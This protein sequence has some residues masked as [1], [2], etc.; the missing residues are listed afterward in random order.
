MLENELVGV[1]RA[2]REAESVAARV[3][4]LEKELQRTERE[5]TE[6]RIGDGPRIRRLR[7]VFALTLGALAA[8]L[9]LLFWVNDANVQR[10]RAALMRSVAENE[11]QARHL[12]TRERELESELARAQERVADLE[13]RLSAPP[14]VPEPPSPSPA[15]FLPSARTRVL[16]GSVVRVSGPT[17]ARRGD[18]CTLVLDVDAGEC[19]AQVRCGVFP[20]YPDPGSGGY[21]PCE[22][23]DEGPVHG[24]DVRRTELSGDPRFDYDRPRHRAIVSDGSGTEAWGVE[25][26]LQ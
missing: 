17:P 7:I 13:E 1:Q 3:P 4:A 10:E 9:A 12:E 6:R 2:R 23:D 25:L 20:L 14:V 24:A 22:A 26:H 8:G 18:P 21:F 15:G 5:L 19:R 11:T 16:S